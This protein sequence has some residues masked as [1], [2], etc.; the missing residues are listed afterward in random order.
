M[1]RQPRAGARQEEVHLLPLSI[2]GLSYALDGRTLIDDIVLDLTAG[3]RT[4]LMG[5]N[6]AGKSLLLRLLHGLLRPSGGEVR[7]NGSSAGAA[8]H[9]RQAM[10]F[11]KPVLLRRSVLA[12]LTHA[13]GARGISRGEARTLAMAWLEEA[14]LANRADQPARSLSGGEQQRL[15]MVRALSLRPEVLLLDEP[16]ANLDPAATQA[17][18]QLVNLAHRGGTKVVLVTHD[19]GQA[20]RIADDIVFMAFGRIL[21]HQPAGRFFEAPLS[22]E[23]QA[24][25]AGDL[26]L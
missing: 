6:G 5:P 9:R 12:N 8:V 3:T 19:I 26:I 20:K 4:V 10:V 25:L 17:I 16:A 18:E 24:F 15:A 22:R 23:G 11:Q 1:A 7:W 13:L 21:E 14:G 2:R